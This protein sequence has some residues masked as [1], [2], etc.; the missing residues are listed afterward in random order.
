MDLGG[1]GDGCDGSLACEAVLPTSLAQDE[2]LLH[3]PLNVLSTP[4]KFRIRRC[5][6]M[7]LCSSGREGEGFGGFTFLMELI[8]TGCPMLLSSA[9]ERFSF[10]IIH[11]IYLCGVSPQKATA[12]LSGEP[13]LSQ[14]SVSAGEPI[15]AV[16]TAALLHGF[17]GAP[18]P[19]LSTGGCIGGHADAVS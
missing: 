10:S 13:E 16:S 7:Q 2:F 11:H 5:P 9:N 3:I 1:G 15:L 17:A 6:E 12:L 18:Y 19:D 14:I 8:I 4:E